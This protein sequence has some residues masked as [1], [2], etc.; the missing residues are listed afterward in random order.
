VAPWRSKTITSRCRVGSAS[1]SPGYDRPG[2]M[3][4]SR[5]TMSFEHGLG[6][7]VIEWRRRHEEGVNEG[8]IGPVVGGAPRHFDVPVSHQAGQ[9]E[10]SVGSVSCRLRKI[11]VLADEIGFLAV[12][13]RNRQSFSH[14][15]RTI[16]K[17]RK[18]RLSQHLRTPW[19]REAPDHVQSKLSLGGGKGVKCCLE[20]LNSTSIPRR[21]PES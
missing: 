5:G 2:T 13:L 6:E 10:S 21:D 16:R 12:I 3:S 17:T 14:L 4:S 19:L 11:V 7:P 18:P 8:I 15:P 9:R 1:T 20:F